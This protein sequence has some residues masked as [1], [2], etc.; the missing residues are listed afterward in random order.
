MKFTEEKLELAIIQL[1]TEQGYPYT[2]GDQ[3]VRSSGDEVLIKEDLR[4]YLKPY[5]LATYTRATKPFVS[6]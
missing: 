6:G 3:L 1:L 5:L 4:Q 2:K